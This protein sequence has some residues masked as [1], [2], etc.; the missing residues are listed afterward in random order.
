MNRLEL[1]FSAA[2]L[3]DFAFLVRDHGFHC[4][5]SELSVRYESEKVFVEVYHGIYDYEIGIHFGR[6]NSSERFD[7]TLYLRRFF[8]D[9]EPLIGSRSADTSAKVDALT[10]ALADALRKDGCRSLTATPILTKR[11][12]RYVGGIFLRKH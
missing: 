5:Q 4:T 9:I 6:L 7:F 12:R 8:P 3:R 10:K 2:V 1:G 11:C